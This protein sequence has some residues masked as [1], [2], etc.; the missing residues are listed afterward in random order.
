MAPVGDVDAIKTI[1]EA[2]DSWLQTI[3]AIISIG[4]GV[5]VPRL[6]IEA[7]TMLN[8]HTTVPTE[9][10]ATVHLLR[11]NLT[12]YEEKPWIIFHA[13]LNA[14][15]EQS[16][17]ERSSQLTST[18]MMERRTQAV[19]GRQLVKAWR[20]NICTSEDVMDPII[21]FQYSIIGL[22]V[23]GYMSSKDVSEIFQRKTYSSWEKCEKTLKLFMQ[24]SMRL[25]AFCKY[26]PF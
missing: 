23:V 24:N 16:F 13:F 1:G 6:L 26:M 22:R 18:N 20:G 15:S 2:K 12:P 7:M 17:L 14:Y 9:I 5:A 25:G 19:I 8:L 21:E 3:C 4:V 11:S 10:G